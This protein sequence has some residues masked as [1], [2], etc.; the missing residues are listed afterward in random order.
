MVILRHTLFIR[1]EAG[2]TP[3]EIRLYQPEHIVEE[4]GDSWGCRFEIDWPDEPKS[5]V[6][7]GFD[8]LQALI[9]SMMG[10]GVHLYISE[11]HEDGVLYAPGRDGGYG[12]PVAQNIRDVLVG[13]D[14]A[15]FWPDA[16]LSPAPP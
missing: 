14:K 13:S 2:D 10:V 3:V 8:A 15:T 11:Y 5:M 16:P 1:G 9:L 4:Y 7:H 12:F 6:I